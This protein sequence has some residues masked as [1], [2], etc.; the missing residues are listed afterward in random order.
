MRKRRKR[1][2]KEEPEEA[3]TT[4]T[5]MQEIYWDLNIIFP[6]ELWLKSVSI[7]TLF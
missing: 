2:T 6:S 3:V 1:E 5:K 7:V 4:D